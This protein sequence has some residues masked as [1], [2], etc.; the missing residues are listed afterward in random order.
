MEDLDSL[1]HTS[2]QNKNHFE[3]KFIFLKFESSWEKYITAYIF[4]EKYAVIS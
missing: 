1:M 4:F 2:I 3:K